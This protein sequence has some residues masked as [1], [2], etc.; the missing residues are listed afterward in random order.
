[1][2][3]EFDWHLTD[4]K[5]ETLV[6]AYHLWYQSETNQKDINI[7]FKDDSSGEFDKRIQVL[8]NRCYKA[9]KF[10]IYVNQ[11]IKKMK[12]NQ[13]EKE[14]QVRFNFIKLSHFS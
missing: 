13:S 9:K 3:G 12:T 8:Y 2:I 14:K 4:V 10:T 7:K 11:D 6:Q 5:R 1:M